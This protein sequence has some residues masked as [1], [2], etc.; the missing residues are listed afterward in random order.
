MQ[1]G[2][3]VMLVEFLGRKVLTVVIAWCHSIEP[4]HCRHVRGLLRL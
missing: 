1:V 3:G 2:R 4:N